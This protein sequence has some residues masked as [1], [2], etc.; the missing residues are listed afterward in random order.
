MLTDEAIA[1]TLVFL[2]FELTLS[3]RQLLR[4]GQR[5][6]I[7]G[8]ALELLAL[9]VAHSGQVLCRRTLLDGIW[10]NMIVEEV[11]LRVQIAALRKLLGDANQCAIVNHPGRGYCFT[12]PVTPFTLQGAPY[13]PAI[14]QLPA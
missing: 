10:P 5:V 2:D 1:D 14:R 4:N 9:L 13:A 3:R 12:V 8:R 11:N 6:A 7:G